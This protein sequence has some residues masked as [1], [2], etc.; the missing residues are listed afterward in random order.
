MYTVLTCIGH[1]STKALRPAEMGPRR[2][3]AER[4]PPYAPALYFCTRVLGGLYMVVMEYPS[5][6][7]SLHRFFTPSQDPP[8]PHPPTADIVRQGLSKALDILHGKGYVFGD[9]CSSNVLYAPGDKRI[10][11]VDPDHVGTDGKDKYRPCF[12]VNQGLGVETWDGMKK[13]DDH[14]N[15]KRVVEGI[16]KAKVQQ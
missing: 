16:P 5:G 13:L 6:A 7:S 10:F 15:L 12:G 8:L 9:L 4:N 1:G 3:L 11:L 2:L 14:K